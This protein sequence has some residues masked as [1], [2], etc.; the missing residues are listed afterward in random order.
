MTHKLFFF[1]GYFAY[2]YFGSFANNLASQ[3]N[4]K[5]LVLGD[6]PNTKKSKLSCKKHRDDILQAKNKRRL[7]DLNRGNPV[8]T[9]IDAL[10]DIMLQDM[11]HRMK[12]QTLDTTLVSLHQRAV[13]MQKQTT[14]IFET[15]KS[16]GDYNPFTK[17]NEKIEA[18]NAQI[19]KIEQDVVQYIKVV[20]TPIGKELFHTPLRLPP[21]QPLPILTSFVNQRPLGAAHV[22]VV[23][24][25]KL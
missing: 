11:T 13:H 1:H 8:T 5:F 3:H 6:P 25:T 10:V 9:G 24:V 19:V 12:T 4:I 20:K 16:T 18:L 7:V 2:A 21:M 15:C 22:L 14:M 23:P 17:H